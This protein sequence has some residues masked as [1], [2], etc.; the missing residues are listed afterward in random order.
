MRGVPPSSPVGSA[1]ID[2][3]LYE[4]DY[5]DYE[6]RTTVDIHEERSDWSI[7]TD[8]AP[9]GESPE[10]IS[11]RVDRVIDR[12]G[13]L[14][15]GACSSRMVTCS[16]PLPSAGWSNPRRWVR[17][18]RSA[19]VACASSVTTEASRPWIDGTPNTDPRT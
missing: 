3:D 9:N 16:A 15:A 6:G 2:A 17:I 10:Q 12:A 4:W 1:E 5:G 8:G 7:W 19:P 14:A 18:C 11:A 13:A